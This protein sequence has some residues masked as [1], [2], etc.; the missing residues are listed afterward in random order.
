M[1][2]SK[3]YF[4]NYATY[5]SH[6]PASANLL[7]I[8]ILLSTLSGSSTIRSEKCMLTIMRLQRILLEQLGA[9]MASNLNGFTSCVF[10]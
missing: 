2:L 6:L 1:T 9:K 8:L 4:E 5:F 10:E 7:T 3:L